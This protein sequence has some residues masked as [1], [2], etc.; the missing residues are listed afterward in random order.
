MLVFW[1]EEADAQ[2]WEKLCR[3]ELAQDDKPSVG[4]SRAGLASA[5]LVLCVGD[6]AA[7]VAEDDGSTAGSCCAFTAYASSGGPTQAGVFLFLSCR[8]SVMGHC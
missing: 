6:G 7:A 8:L 5:K 1:G 3:R 2:R 4:V